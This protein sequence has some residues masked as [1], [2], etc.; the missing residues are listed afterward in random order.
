[1]QE[2]LGLLLNLLPFLVLTKESQKVENSADPEIWHGDIW[3]G[4]DYDEME[5]DSDDP[6]THHFQPYE[7]EASFVNSLVGTRAQMQ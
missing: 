3:H 7:G 4:D 2:K 5:E 6:S 1:M